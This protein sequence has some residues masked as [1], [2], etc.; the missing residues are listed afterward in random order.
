M[1]AHHALAKRFEAVR[2]QS[3]RYGDKPTLTAQFWSCVEQEERYMPAGAWHQNR[4]QPSV[5]RRQRIE[6]ERD[7]LVSCFGAGRHIVELARSQTARDVL[8]SQKQLI[9]SDPHQCRD[10]GLLQKEID[11]G[12][13]QLLREL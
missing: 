4:S 9:G 8:N 1:N 12:L 6:N 13:H 10:A 3:Q 7:R 2:D 11:Q 5:R